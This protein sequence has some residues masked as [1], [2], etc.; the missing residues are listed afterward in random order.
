MHLHKLI[1]HFTL[2]KFGS[3]PPRGN[4]T[5]GPL[6]M[7]ITPTPKG[8][9]GASGLDERHVYISS[10]SRSDHRTPC[11]AA[12]ITKRRIVG[13]KLRE[14][15][16][17][18]YVPSLHNESSSHYPDSHPVE[19][20]GFL[21]KRP[22]VELSKASPSQTRGQS[23]VIKENMTKSLGSMGW[24]TGYKKGQFGIQKSVTVSNKQPMLL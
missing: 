15:V 14:F 9:R 13:L 18:F 10:L 23:Q 22:R 6:A 5:C 3:T 8:G 17:F 19:P 11:T 4:E 24:E 2:S 12:S 21:E 20:R 1:P 16:V 7:E